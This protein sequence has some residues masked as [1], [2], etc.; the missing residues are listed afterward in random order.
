MIWFKIFDYLSYISRTPQDNT[1]TLKLNFKLEMVSRECTKILS[2][3]IDH[4]TAPGRIQ[5]GL[6]GPRDTG[7]HVSW[8]RH[9]METFSA[10]LALCA[11][12][13]PV[14]GEFH[15]QR[16]VTRSFDVFF[17]LRLKKNR[18]VNNREAGDLRRHR[19]HYDVIVMWVPFHLPKLHEIMVRISNGGFL[20]GAITHLVLITKAVWASRRWSR[21]EWVMASHHFGSSY[22]AVPL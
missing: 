14:S 5:S 9:Q 8:W 11:G 6:C 2:L 3:R 7:K 22:C 17:D 19:A 1:M 13:S 12:N 16:P 20:G 21:Y 15:A 18:W 10:L 4:H